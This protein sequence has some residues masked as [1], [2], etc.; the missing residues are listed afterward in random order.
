MRTAEFPSSEAFDAIAAAISSDAD[1]KA[2]IKQG[3][4]IFAFHLKN[5]AGKE[6][7]WYL[8]LKETGAVGKGPGPNGKKAGGK[9]PRTRRSFMRETLIRTPRAN[10]PC[11]QPPPLR[12]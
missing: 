4:A 8:D 12:G 6:A 2:A 9:S 3:G 10:T 11:S 1:K 5:K 7:S